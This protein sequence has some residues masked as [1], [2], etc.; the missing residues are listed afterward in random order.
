MNIYKQQQKAKNVLVVK[1]SVQHSPFDSPPDPSSH[2]LS[3]YLLVT[4]VE[5]IQQ[6]SLHISS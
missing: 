6:D 1:N 5:K 4:E 2:M 3:K